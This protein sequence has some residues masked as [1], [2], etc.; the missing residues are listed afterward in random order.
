MDY[1][2]SLT[3]SVQA[4]IQQNMAARVY[5]ANRDTMNRLA[6]EVRENLKDN[7]TVNT[8]DFVLRRYIQTHNPELLEGLRYDD[9]TVSGN[10]AWPE[11][12][13]AVL[14]KRLQEISRD[15]HGLTALTAKSWRGYLTGAGARVRA[16]VMKLAFV[17]QMSPEDTMELL[18]AFN[19]ETY[20]VRYPMD[21]IC[22]FCQHLP[23]A[24]TWKDVEEM[25]A[26]FEASGAETGAEGD[27]DPTMTKEM[28]NSLQEIFDS[29]RPEADAKQAVVDYMITHAKEFVS[30][31]KGAKRMYLPGFSYA[32]MRG[33]LR[34]AQYLRLLYPAYYTDTTLTTNPESERRDLGELADG[35]P[36]LADLRRAMF[37]RQGWDVELWNVPAGTGD[38][39]LQFCNNYHNHMFALDRL[40]TGGANVQ[41]FERRDALLLAYF[42]IQG[43]LDDLRNPENGVMDA[44]NDMVCEKG[45]MDEGI[46]ELFDELDAYYY[47]RAEDEDDD[48]NRYTTMVTCVNKILTALDYIPLYVP[49]PFDRFIT[50][51]LLS[52]H[53]DDFASLV[54]YEGNEE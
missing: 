9:L 48:L 31:S 27:P 34:I 54:I 42:L 22:L 33:F 32:R 30:F 53:P 16:S 8:P 39:M 50:L 6:S 51:S 26:A 2:S 43:Y 44:I 47:D 14:A 21:F 5:Q 24:Y 4:Y 36:K 18:M 41:F 13:I 20:S 40:R 25:M 23:G 35:A 37:Q 11:E 45:P 28:K 52:G 19:M 3:A 12:T 38:A 29:G 7:S 17:V 10:V 46:G 49:A 15:V 1:S